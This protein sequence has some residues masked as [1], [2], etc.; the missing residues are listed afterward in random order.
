M[1]GRPFKSLL[2]SLARPRICDFLVVLITLAAL[3][4][5]VSS[6]RG[7]VFVPDSIGYFGPLADWQTGRGFTAWYGRGFGYPL[8]VTALLQDG[9]HY[10]R[11]LDAQMLLLAGTYVF[12]G[13]V[14]WRCGRMLVHLP[15][16]RSLPAM[17]LLMLGLISFDF[18]ATH[19]ALMHSALPEIMFIAVLALQLFLMWKTLHTHEKR[20]Q[21][22]GLAGVTF[23]GFMLILIK[24]H[25]LLTALILPPVLAVL[26]LQKLAGKPLVLALLAGCLSAMPFHLFDLHQKASYDR[27]A[28]KTF[29]PRTLFCNNLNV[30]DL[31]FARG[32]EDTLA[33]RP[34]IEEILEG[35]PQG[36]NALGFN[37]DA[38]MYGGLGRTV[39]GHFKDDP[40]KE[41]NYY[42]STTVSAALI[43]PDMVLYRLMRQFKLV[44][45]SP[46]VRQRVYNTDCRP[47]E[48][49]IK[50][51]AFFEK[52]QS[53]CFAH[54]DDR[55]SYFDIKPVLFNWIY[56]LL[57][58]LAMCRLAF[59][60]F[61]T[62]EKNHPH[63]SPCGHM[64]TAAL[65]ATFS[66]VLFVGLV[67]SFDVFRYMTMI[68]PLILVSFCCMTVWLF[69]IGTRTSDFV[70]SY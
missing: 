1:I 13:W 62:E 53:E 35:G 52:L 2:V 34:Q 19:L 20:A 38:C 61:G 27:F 9:T 46:F 6:G 55:I 63:P 15:A 16:S 25:Y 70:D 10:L 48:E 58:G 60:V 12:A 56:A 29:G 32:M 51:N 50:R 28:A 67:H 23:I 40:D 39:R 14:V 44:L 42:I 64:G 66:F 43:A 11:V 57:L 37:G 30:L 4:N 45:F 54:K 24:P 36:W 65:F 22:A 17:G 5:L 33:I 7:F 21:F 49:G 3:I 18:N 8:L 41:A 47:L 59:V 26:L 68:S 69:C 31:A